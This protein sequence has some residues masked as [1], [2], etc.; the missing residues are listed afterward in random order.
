MLLLQDL[1]GS[2]T[3]QYSVMFPCLRG[4]IAG[5]RHIS[6]LGLLV[7]KNSNRYTQIYELS[8]L[9]CRGFVSPM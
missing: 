2:S 7:N 8:R 6:K 1:N 5:L 4:K 9:Y 3:L